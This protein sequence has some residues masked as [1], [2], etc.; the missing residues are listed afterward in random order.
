MSEAE[1]PIDIHY[2][3]LVDWLVSVP[4]PLGVVETTQ[5]AVIR[6]ARSLGASKFAVL[7]LD[8]WT[9][10]RSRVTGASD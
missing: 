10:R 1:L 2:D 4:T 5:P 3:K 8:R 6:R 9:G 7:W